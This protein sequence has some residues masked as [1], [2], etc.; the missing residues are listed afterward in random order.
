MRYKLRPI[1]QC[2]SR[3]LLRRSRRASVAA[4]LALAVMGLLA[5]SSVPDHLHLNNDPG[6]YN[7]ECPLA[8]SEA[9]HR[10]VPLPAMSFGDWVPDVVLRLAVSPAEHKPDSPLHLAASRAPPLA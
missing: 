10:G 7:A 3:S 4:L 6:I 5:Q 2:L 8:A 1:M 9:V